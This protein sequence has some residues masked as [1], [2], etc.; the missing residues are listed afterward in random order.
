MRQ[1]EV[2]YIY[3]IVKFIYD[4]YSTMFKN[5]LRIFIIEIVLKYFKLYNRI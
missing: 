5:Y 1:R 2:S 4:M 3:K